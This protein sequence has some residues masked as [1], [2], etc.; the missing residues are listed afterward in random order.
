MGKNILLVWETGA[1]EGHLLQLSWLA[2]ALRARG[3]RTHFALARKSRLASLGDSLAS[4]IIQSPRWPGQID[5]TSFQLPAP[6]TGLA[7][8]LHRLGL[9]APGAFERV[10]RNWSDVF[11]S[12]KPDVVV[13]DAA[14]ACL[15]AARGQI[16][17]V[18]IGNGFTLP[19]TTVERFARF[20]ADGQPP[21]TDEERLLESANV[22]LSATG[23]PPLR[24]LSELYRADRTCVGTFVELDPYAESR[25]TSPVAPWLP[26]WAGGAA[27]QR[28]EVFCYLGFNIPERRFLLIALAQAVALGVAVS[29]HI[30]RLDADTATWLERSRVRVE[31][32]PLTLREIQSRARLV[33]SF[34]SL[35]FVSFALAAGIPQIVVP[36][37]VSHAMTGRVVTELGAGQSFKLDM[38]SWLEAELL[39]RAIQRAAASVE[40]TARAK[41]LAPRFIRRVFPRT[42][43]VAASMVEELL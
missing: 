22:G 17:T 34:G 43:E 27:M 25:G 23:R 24:R 35:G 6:T 40:L 14:P 39:A 19:P 18:A 2:T 1:G 31:L 37:S 21:Q 12:T 42:A 8:D 20:G 32:K 4:D 15:A 9:A 3:H 16:P 10:L 33:I 30:P 13:A 11:A 29:V 41:S 38:G 26:E 28:Q 36:H 7:D 5:R